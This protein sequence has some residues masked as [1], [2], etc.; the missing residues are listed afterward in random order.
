MEF[1]LFISQDTIFL[2]Y[3]MPVVQN[4]K[5]VILQSLSPAN[6]PSTELYRKNKNVDFSIFST[7]DWDHLLGSNLDY[8]ES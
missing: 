2:T 4:L 3:F 1:I 7:S 8:L 5:K 6:G